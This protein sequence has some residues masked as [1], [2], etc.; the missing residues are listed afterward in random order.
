VKKIMLTF[1]FVKG[2]K[3]EITVHRADAVSSPVA[4][5]SHCQVGLITI[6]TGEDDFN[7]PIATINPAAMTR[8]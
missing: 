5:S 3:R 7:T 2:I 6:E 8:F 4:T 1:L